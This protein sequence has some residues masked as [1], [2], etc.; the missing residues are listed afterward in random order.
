M[1]KLLTVLFTLFLTSS[2]LA[3]SASA[4]EESAQTDA[5]DCVH[6][7]CGAVDCTENH[8]D[9]GS[10]NWQSWDGDLT[11]GKGDGSSAA[12]YLHLEDDLTITDTL[13][14]TDRDV[15]L[16]LNG[17]TLTIDKEGYPAVS[18]GSN[19]KFVLC[20]CGETGKITGAKGSAESDTTRFAAINCQSGDFV[21]YGGSIADNEVANSNGGGVFVSGG[22]FTM[23]GGSFVNNKAPNGSGGAVSVENGTITVDGGEMIGNSAVNGGAIHLKNKA[24]ADLSNAKFRNNSATGSKNSGLGGAIFAETRDSL[25]IRDVEIADNTAMHGGGICVAGFDDNNSYPFFYTNIYNADIHNNTA[26]GNGGGV[27]LNGNYKSNQFIYMYNCSVHDNFA[28][29][30]GGGY[31]VKSEAQL[32]LN[33]GSIVGNSCNGGGGGIRLDTGSYFNVSGSDGIVSITGNRAKLGGGISASGEYMTI[34]GQCEIKDNT[35]LQSGGGM[36]IDYIYTWLILIKTNVTQN[37]AP[38]GGGICLN[39]KNTDGRELEIGGGT[40]VFG[41]TTPDGAKSN[42]YLMNGKK[43]QFRNGLNGSEKIGVSASTVPTLEDPL[44]IEYVFE[45]Q[46]HDK[47]GDRSALLI[48]DDENYTVLY[49]NEMHYLVPKYHTVTLDLQ[50]GEESQTVKVEYGGT[51]DRE[52]LPVPIWD[53][54]SFDT[55]YLNGAAYNFEK[56]IND[57]LTLTARWIKIGET[58]LS[59]DGDTVLV[60]GLDRSAVLIVA[61]YGEN[62]LLNIAKTELDKTEKAFFSLT[63]LGINTENATEVKAFLWD[64]ADGSPFAFLRPLCESAAASCSER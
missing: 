50:N 7:V 11:V 5:A 2:V 31:Y 55:W 53:G 59:V 39:K 63:D 14:V 61:S 12:V 16:C 1:K 26:R 34:N 28:E 54:Y 15:Y 41:N 36:Y 27:F 32:Q 47:G 33:G 29:W 17:K 21:M 3:L 57:D 4:Q 44:A 51:L 35:A 64:N 20:D 46:Y 24:K 58:A 45:S 48:P 23:H 25:T 9:T 10:V 52:S 43:F 56:P 49:E 42:L 6:C 37:T 38:M 18:I 62:G 8:E 30:N 13:T 60:F 40:N 19:G 22:S